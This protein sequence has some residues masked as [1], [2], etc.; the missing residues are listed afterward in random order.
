MNHEAPVGSHVWRKATEANGLYCNVILA[1]LL[2]DCLIRFVGQGWWLLETLWWWSVLACWGV[3]WSLRDF[4]WCNMP[5][6]RG[7]FVNQ[8]ICFHFPLYTGAVSNW[9]TI[10]DVSSYSHYRTCWSN[11]CPASPTYTWELLRWTLTTLCCWL[12]SKWRSKTLL[13]GILPTTVT[14]GNR[15]QSICLPLPTLSLSLVIFFY[16]LLPF[17]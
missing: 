12:L 8:L 17:F 6:W 15:E 16:W 3:S 1:M 4:M 11:M 14:E 5:T 2:F 7:T 10:I 13:K 9:E